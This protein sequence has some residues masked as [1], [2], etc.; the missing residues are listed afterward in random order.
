[1]PEETFVAMDRPIV[2][3]A[4][5]TTE[6]RVRLPFDLDDDYGDD[7]IYSMSY[8]ARTGVVTERVAREADVVVTADEAAAA[9]VA[10]S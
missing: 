6:P 7:S 8:R 10:R 5:K 9:K 3:S 4:A 2:N 1:M